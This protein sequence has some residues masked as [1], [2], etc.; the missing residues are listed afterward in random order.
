MLPAAARGCPRLP[1]AARGCLRL[2]AQ[3]CVV[4]DWLSFCD[5]MGS[6][7]GPSHR[8]RQTR[9][10]VDG[11]SRRPLRNGLLDDLLLVK[12]TENA[13]FHPLGHR[14][15]SGVSLHGFGRQSQATPLPKAGFS[16][17]PNPPHI[18]NITISRN[19]ENHEATFCDAY[20][21][22][23]SIEGRARVETMGPKSRGGGSPGPWPESAPQSSDAD[24]QNIGSTG[25][26][27]WAARLTPKVPS[28]RGRARPGPLRTSPFRWAASSGAGC[29]GS[30]SKLCVWWLRNFGRT[31]SYF[32][33]ILRTPPD[34]PSLELPQS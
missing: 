15:R 26:P 3:V 6:S 14:M 28:Q 16:S 33:S 24:E 29:T 20:L 1:T 5:G 12:S 10:A 19:P 17:F 27:C 18:R 32:E 25:S 9:A 34:R 13:E 30:A 8:G 23:K 7:R 11:P 31:P 2:P 21:G 4:P 22:A